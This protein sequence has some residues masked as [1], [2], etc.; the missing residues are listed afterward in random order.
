MGH[1]LGSGSGPSGGIPGN[2][3]CPKD[4]P[5]VFQE[6]RFR[7]VSDPFRVF[8]RDFNFYLQIPVQ[9]VQGNTRK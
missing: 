7:D 9:L 1:P 4:V 5:G 8:P 3:G 6:P 2:S